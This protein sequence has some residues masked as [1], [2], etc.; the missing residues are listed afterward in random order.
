MD[1]TCVDV[2]DSRCLQFFELNLRLFFLFPL[3]AL[4]FS[5]FYFLRLKMYFLGASE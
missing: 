5:I 3:S 1:S 2:D 4:H